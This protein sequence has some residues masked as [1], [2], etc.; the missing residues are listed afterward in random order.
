LQVANAGAGMW[1]VLEVIA[2]WP[3]FSETKLLI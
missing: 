2:M 3:A 1:R